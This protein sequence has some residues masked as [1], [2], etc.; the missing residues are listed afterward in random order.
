MEDASE[1]FKYCICH[2]IFA[3]F[4]FILVSFL[5]FEHISYHLTAHNGKFYENE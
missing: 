4:L 2:Q 3:F 1:S 5:S